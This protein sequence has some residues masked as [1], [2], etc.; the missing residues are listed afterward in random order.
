M[1]RDKD[2]KMVLIGGA[3]VWLS[4]VA[5]VVP[6]NHPIVKDLTF[7]P[8]TKSAICVESSSLLLEDEREPQD[9]VADIMRD[10]R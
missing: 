7:R 2:D 3:W 9:L 8:R 10:E 5:S 6:L 1:A 4:D